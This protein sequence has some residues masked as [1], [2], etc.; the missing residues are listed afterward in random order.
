M[1]DAAQQ[2][3][4]E[5]IDALTVAQT[6][7][8]VEQHWLNTLSKIFVTAQFTACNTP[9]PHCRIGDNNRDLLVPSFG[10]EQHY[11]VSQNPGAAFN[12][13]DAH[14]IESLLKLSR[15]FCS[16]CR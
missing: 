3:L 7:R 1:H 6:S 5:L 4:L 10:N 11:V 9:L 15:Q 13:S 8:D 12:H 14:F 16:M 2:N